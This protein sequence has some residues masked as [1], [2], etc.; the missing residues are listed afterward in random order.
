MVS[1]V[2][3]HSPLTGH[4]AWGTLPD[5]LRDEGHDA[6]VLDVIDDD[7]PPYAVRYVA[8]AAAQVA[9]AQPAAPLI[10]V[11][12]S[13]AGY[14]LPQLGFTQRAARRAVRGYVFLDAGIPAPRP[15]TRLDLLAGEDA[16]MA[17][18]LAGLL[19]AGGRFPTWSDEDLRDL[20][21]DDSRRA[22]VVG[23]LRPRSR[24]FFTE[25]LPFPAGELDWP[26]APCAL[27]QTSEGYAGPAASARK[28]GWPVLERDGGHFVACADPRGLA[29]DLL[30]LVEQL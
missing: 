18:D 25:V 5:V 23:S 28:R 1:F 2:L 8:A 6:L 13:G 21:P 14:L 12:H 22:S 16:V 17:A 7:A 20:I 3:A 19:A 11:A 24:D 26:D 30:S 29:R 10:L 15:T 27:L 9:A 4:A